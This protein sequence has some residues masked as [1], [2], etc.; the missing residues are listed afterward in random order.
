MTTA[1][2]L[3]AVAPYAAW[4]ARRVARALRRLRLDPDD[5][6]QEGMLAAFRL[7]PHYDPSGGRPKTFAAARVRGAMIDYVRRCGDE[8]GRAHFLA[9]NAANWAGGA[10]PVVHHAHMRFPENVLCVRDPEPADPPEAEFRAFVREIADVP[11]SDVEFLVDRYARGR[12]LR[13]IGAAR[14]V[15]ESRASQ[16]HARIVSQVRKAAAARGWTAHRPKEAE[17]PPTDC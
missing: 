5:L 13:E 11:P 14:G 7:A 1:E 8:L 15:S 16:E 10:V 6:Y 2:F 3:A 9:A 12:L 4:Y 17:C